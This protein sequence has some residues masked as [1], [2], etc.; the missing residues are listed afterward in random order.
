MTDAEYEAEMD[1]LHGC[2][3]H[4][5]EH[6]FTFTRRELEWPGPFA[7]KGQRKLS[8]RIV[9]RCPKC[10]TDQMASCPVP[11]VPTSVRVIGGDDQ[12]SDACWRWGI[13]AMAALLVATLAMAAINQFV[14]LLKALGL[15]GTPG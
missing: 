2:T 12:K 5:C 10:L 6:Q 15:L 3:C 1:K 9:C 14:S 4:R 8:D 11:F 13:A 7:P